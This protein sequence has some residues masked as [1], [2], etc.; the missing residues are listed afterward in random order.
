MPYSMIEILLLNKVKIAIGSNAGP[1]KGG[2]LQLNPYAG[3][4]HKVGRSWCMR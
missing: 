3:F 1:V 2:G 4:S